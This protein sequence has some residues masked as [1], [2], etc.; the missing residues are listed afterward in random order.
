VKRKFIETLKIAKEQPVDTEAEKRK[1]AGNT[2]LARKSLNAAV[3]F[4]ALAT[5]RCS[6]SAVYLTNRATAYLRG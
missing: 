6:K 4:F 1:N 2:A 3:S 5:V